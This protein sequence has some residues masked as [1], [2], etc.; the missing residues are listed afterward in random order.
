MTATDHYQ[1]YDGASGMTDAYNNTPTTYDNTP[2][3]TSPAVKPNTPPLPPGI[4]L[5]DAAVM[6]PEFLSNCSS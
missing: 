5:C 6:A 3:T 4:N 1:L 2:N